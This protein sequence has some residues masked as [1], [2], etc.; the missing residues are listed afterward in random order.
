MS[1]D[2]K[3]RGYIE[4]FLV[5]DCETTGL[6]Y[7]SDDP[8]YDPTTGKSYQAVSWGLI[9]A[10]AFTLKPIETL[11]VEIKWNGESEWD[12]R[13]QQIHGLTLEYLEANGMTE[14]DA[15][16]E[17]ASLIL[18]HWGPDSPVHLGGHNVATFDRYFFRRLMRSQG[19]EIKLGNKYI[20]SN[21]VGFSTFGTHNSDDLFEA[22]GLPDRDPNKHNALVDAENTLTTLRT[23]KQLFN[24]CLEGK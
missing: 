24:A 23:V 4:K 20:D 21:S 15:V 22:V 1:K 8:S 19:I 9:V 17:I 7:G 2:T 14:E 3:P 10:D 5:I 6:A 13:A 18:K 16:V 12:M 11:Y